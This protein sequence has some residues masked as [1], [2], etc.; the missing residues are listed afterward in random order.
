MK[1]LEAKKKRRKRPTHNEDR[2]Q[3]QCV[4]WFDRNYPPLK[5]LLHHSPNGG[6]RSITEGKTFKDMGTRAGFPDLILLLYNNRYNYL[7]IEMKTMEKGSRQK[8][9]QKEYEQLMNAFGGCYRVVRSKEEFIE[10]VTAYINNK[11]IP[12]REDERK[13]SK[14]RDTKARKRTSR[15]VEGESSELLQGLL[16]EK[17]E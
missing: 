12:N 17:E 6:A 13:T 1:A 4:D 8:P 16:H 5:K 9:E 10:L 2:I 11:T 15:E 14:G 7:A 3:M